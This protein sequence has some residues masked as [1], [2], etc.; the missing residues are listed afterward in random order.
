MDGL[1][2]NGRRNRNRHQIVTVIDRQ[3]D[4]AERRWQ[5]N[6]GGE[7]HEITDFRGRGTLEN[8]LGERSD[9]HLLAVSQAVRL[10]RSREP[11]VDGMCRSEPAGFESEARKQGVRLD[12]LFD[13]GSEQMIPRRVKGR[14]GV[15]P[16]HVP[17]ESG[18]C[19]AGQGGKATGHCG[20]E[21][22]GGRARLEPG[23]ESVANPGGEK[24]GRSVDNKLRV[25]QHQIRIARKES[26]FLE[27]ALLGVDHGEC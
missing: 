6:P 25:D 13:R 18:E 12:H 17:T 5:A 20:R 7:L 24:S 14:E 8:E 15:F 11:V 27:H 9:I 2:L 3:P 26:V 23:G 21:R 19:C 16:E 1:A 22:Q 10:G 4:L